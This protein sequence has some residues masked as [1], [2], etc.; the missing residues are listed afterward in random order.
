[1]RPRAL[2]VEDDRHTQTLLERILDAEG[3]DVDVAS[4]GD[5]AIALLCAIR[6]AIVLVDIVLPT[7]SG[8]IVMEHLRE[9]D[10]EL[11][12][13]V[14]V[15]T[16]LDVTEIRKLFPTV[17]LALSKPVLPGRLRATVRHCLPGFGPA[18]A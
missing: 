17:K 3:F 5:V 1:M 16:G 14:I 9:H 15:V 18:V 12:E 10:P 4:D 11:L 7:V 8:M 13:R 2:V 6:Y